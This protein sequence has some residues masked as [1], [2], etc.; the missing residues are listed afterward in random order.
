LPSRL[1]DPQ[2]ESAR[3][4]PWQEMFSVFG[5]RATQSVVMADRTGQ[6]I[7]ANARFCALAGYSPDEI[8]KL[9]C[10]NL[11]SES[12]LRP[13]ST[14]PNQNQTEP[15]P[16]Q[17]RCR[18]GAAYQMVA[19]TL[20]THIL[21]DGSWLGFVDPAAE[22]PDDAGQQA[23]LAKQAC[24]DHAPI[25]IFRLGPTGQV[26]EVN[27]QGCRDLGYTREELLSQTVFDFD[28][29]ITPEKWREHRHNL[30][31]EGQR[32]LEGVH[33]QKDGT[34]H[35][36]EV[37]V[38]NFQ[39][40]GR[41][42]TF[43]FVQDIT[44][45]KAAE[46]ALKESAE[47]FRQLAEAAFEGIAVTQQGHF[48]DVNDQFARMVG[49]TREA[50]LHTPVSEC[51]APEHRERVAELMRS[52]Q[53]EPFEHLALRKDGTVFTA[54][55]RLRIV[56]IG[57]QEVCISAIRDITER[58][59]LEAALRKSEFLLRKSQAV[60][61]TGSYYFD[62]RTGQWISSP[63]LDLLFGIDDSYPKDVQGWKNLLH[64]DDREEIVRYLSQEVLARHH[65]FDR[66]YRILRHDDHQARWVHGVGELEF[67]DQGHVTQMIGTL[68]DI[69]A[70]KQAELA[71]TELRR[72][73]QEAMHIAQMG[74]WEFD[75]ASG[76]FTFNDQYYRLHRLT[77]AEAGGYRMSAETF[78][79]RYVHPDDAHI[80]GE[81]IQAAIE[82]SE[83][84]YQTIFEARILRIDGQARDV[85]VW[86]R[87]EKDSQGRTTKLHGVNQDITERKRL[88]RETEQRR[89]FLE[90]ILASTPDAIITAD[91]HHRVL[92]W[93]PGAQA[94]F[95][96]TPQEACGRNIDDLV[97][98]NDPAAR[99]EA[100]RWTQQ[101]QTSAGLFS[102]ETIRYRKDGSPVNVRVSVAPLL[103]RADWGGVVAV[104][105]DITDQKKVEQALRE[106]EGRYRSLVEIA[107][108]LI[109]IHRAGKMVF[110]N[111]AGARMLGATSP[112]EIVGLPVGALVAPTARLLARERLQ[113][114]HEMPPSVSMYEQRLRRRDGQE[115]DAEVTGVA[116]PYQGDT[117]IQI[118]ARD[119]T[120]QKRAA[121]ERRRLAAIL[122]N[123][124]DLV[125]M[126]TPDSH[127][128]YLNPAGR[129]ML[130]WT[131]SPPI[132]ERVIAEMHPEWALAAIQ[133]TAIPLAIEKGFWQGETA[134]CN[135]GGSETQV[136][137]VI[138]VHRSMDGELQYLSTVMR[139]ITESKQAEETI[140]QLNE[141]LEERVRERTARLEAANQELEAFTYS[142]SHDL[143]APLR[144]I[145]GYTRILSEE[146][147]SALDAEGQRVCAV[148][149]RQAQRMGQLIDDLLTFSR[150]GRAA[151]QVLPVDMQAL[152]SG[153][154]HDLTHSIPP[155]RIT[156]QLAPLPTALAD[157]GLMRQVW[158]NLLSN[159]IKFSRQQEP[160]LIEVGSSQAAGEITYWVRDNGAGF[161][162]RYADK[163]FG[164]F[165]RLHS[166]KQFEG[167][168]VG[169][170]IV[171]RV[172]QRHGGRV[173]ATSTVNHGAT[174]FF[175]LAQK[176]KQ[177]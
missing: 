66:E 128:I 173:W 163:L 49:Y 102:D 26:L 65:R 9:S 5:E 108:Y 159:A 42:F 50:L 47:R 101:I 129:R 138:L 98:G 119:I 104:Y 7:A 14:W 82:A 97:T 75:V 23:L 120:E 162:M 12:D 106:S 177:A 19:T 151:M 60:S 57:D 54:E 31:T 80:V 62:A 153:I 165:Q 16:A 149:S 95:G 15:A 141:A 158:I 35:P 112:D 144:A 61:Q 110:I 132:T 152:V 17:L 30:T 78:A 55:T 99:A 67:N 113:P 123:T 121:D 11:F 68:Q 125:A 2:N 21:S 105:Q 10:L 139:D 34:T 174:F 94:L 170:A 100:T 155:G 69:T 92:E 126:A 157:P 73:D 4:Q 134:I 146:Y 24:V 27:D 116:F 107:P 114:G 87:A 154:Y 127:L 44:Q 28:P 145:D 91:N 3:Q 71:L 150:L 45:R 137:Q 109:G 169:L 130:G 38:C 156:F 32:T 51:I 63:A 56:D 8:L 59:Q 167:T 22:P 86:F 13:N 72:Q 81:V 39:L 148:I 122:E 85:T 166:E 143:R 77:A 117:A 48:L 83:P 175:T 111:Q 84:E 41:D 76:E 176:G 168:G 136:S 18:R 140:R 52:N 20:T 1:Q 79:H 133:E 160:A 64:P 6:V 88:E 118:T 25:A 171:H 53:L 115:I 74:H 96:Y 172:I 58:T 43:S 135:Q 131:V 46:V 40:Q 70:R 89:L 124:S 103:D 90:S 33:R 37:I 147:G 29:G 161:D 142:V 93:N 164:V 36:V